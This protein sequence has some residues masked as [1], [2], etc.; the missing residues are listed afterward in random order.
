MA[1]VY[2]AAETLL[3]REGEI[4]A[5]QRH[6]LLGLIATEAVRLKQITEEVLL[7]TQLDRGD[8]RLERRPVDIIELARSAVERLE[9]QLL[10]SGSVAVEAPV[11]V[12][13]ATGD[14]DRIQQIL[15]NLLDNALKYGGGAVTMRVEAVNGS[16]RVSVTDNGP[17]IARSDQQRIFE[18]F[19]RADPE[20][21]QVPGG[22][23]LGLYIARELTRRMDGRLVVQSQPGAGATFVLELPRA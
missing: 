1:A 21:R 8:L 15:I 18:K 17:G 10:E 19:Y 16:V 7:T 23:G 14:A 20:Q 3:H 4:T 22:T 2:G 11:D 13:A 6:Q 9:P 12:G 5:Q